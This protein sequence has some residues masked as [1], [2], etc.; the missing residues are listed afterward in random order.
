MFQRF[1][2][3]SSSC[4]DWSAWAWPR[5]SWNARSGW[6]YLSHWA[7]HRISKT[8][9]WGMYKISLVVTLSLFIKSNIEGFWFVFNLNIIAELAVTQVLENHMLWISAGMR[10]FLFS[11]NILFLWQKFPK[12]CV[13]YFVWRLQ[14]RW[15]FG[16]DI[17]VPL[18]FQTC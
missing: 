3:R 13:M 9:S 15:D 7:W 17:G 8:G 12:Q 2:E 16:M 4:R 6:S 11:A 10:I 1:P 18:F 14:I 5:S